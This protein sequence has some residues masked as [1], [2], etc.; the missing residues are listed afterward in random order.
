MKKTYN[1]VC[2]GGLGKLK[3][4]ANRIGHMGIVTPNDIL[5]TL[6]SIA[7]SLDR[8]GMRTDAKTSISSAKEKLRHL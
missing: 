1:V 8:L 2:A 7:V 6:N 5:V 4:I 3:G